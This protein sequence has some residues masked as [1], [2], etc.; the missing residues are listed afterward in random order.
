MFRRIIPDSTRTGF[1]CVKHNINI[2]VLKNLKSCT[3]CFIMEV[4]VLIANIKKL[5]G[6]NMKI[7]VILAVMTQLSLITLIIL[8]TKNRSLSRLTKTGI[9]IT[10]AF[11]MACSLAELFGVLLDGS[12]SS[13]RAVHILVKFIEFSLAPV[14]PVAFSTAFY[15]IKSKRIVF[16]PTAIHIILETLSLFFGFIFYVDGDNLYH[17]GKAYWIYYFFI[18]LG[19]L[20]LAHTT[21]HFGIQFQNRNNLSLLTL[22]IFTLFGVTLQIVD[23][24]IK[25]VWLTVAIGMILFYIYYCNMVYQIDVM[26]E[27]LNRRSYENH[28][29]SLKRSAVVLFFDVNSFKSINDRFG[30]AYGDLCLKNVAE[31]IKSVYGRY[32]LCY[33]LGGD[34]FCVIID[35]KIALLN[36]E[37][38]SKKFEQALLNKNSAN[39][40]MPTVAIGCAYFDPKKTDISNA[41]A[42]ADSQMY[43]NKKSGKLHQENI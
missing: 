17:H 34:E 9:I 15:P 42:E 2:K 43:S 35:R 40:T 25:I 20:F 31:A 4:S 30:H 11:I 3:V 36:T 39:F 37:S 28:K 10:S 19:V 18:S 27:L 29:S 6:S 41:I 22:L 5:W 8:I 32:G 12:S 24:S 14:I 33:R 1:A 23:N 38:L 7:Y 21:V 16:V 13:L 26:T